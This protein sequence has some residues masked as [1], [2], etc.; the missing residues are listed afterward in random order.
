MEQFLY[1]QIVQAAGM[2]PQVSVGFGSFWNFVF[3]LG[4][5]VGIVGS[6]VLLFIKQQPLP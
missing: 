3:W 4:F 5:F 2:Q 1:Q 6:G